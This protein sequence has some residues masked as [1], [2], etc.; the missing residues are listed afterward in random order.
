MTDNKDPEAR[1]H[2]PGSKVHGL[3]L[4]Q[5]RAELNRASL[6][7][8]A[9]RGPDDQG[10]SARRIRALRATGNG[11]R[12]PSGGASG[13]K[14]QKRNLISPLIAVRIIELLIVLFGTVIFYLAY[15]LGWL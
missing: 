9:D 12:N 10:E 13:Q 15:R 11:Q 14:R 6:R 3:T 8:R 7:E 5:A 2:L 1:L 4:D